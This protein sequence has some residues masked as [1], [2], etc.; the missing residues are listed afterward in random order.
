MKSKSIV[1]EKK[2][3]NLIKDLLKN[4]QESESLFNTCISKLK[5]ELLTA[6][7][8]AEEDFP[9]GVI[10]L[11]SIVDIETP[12]GQMKTQLVLPKDSN[13]NQKK[14][15]LLTPMGSALLGYKEGDEVL[16]SFPSGEQMI[17]IIR[18]SNFD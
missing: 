4:I 9:E 1:I 16:W 3:Y 18:V 2:E 15:S 7:I 10:R 13:S 12:F 6:E 5:N 11:N 14:I 8:V 17:K